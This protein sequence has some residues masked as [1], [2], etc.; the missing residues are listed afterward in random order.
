VSVVADGANGRGTKWTNS[1]LAPS[2]TT[3][4][5]GGS[6]AYISHLFCIFAPLQN[7]LM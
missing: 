2:A 1:L 5:S 7:P 4:Y 3:D 6:F